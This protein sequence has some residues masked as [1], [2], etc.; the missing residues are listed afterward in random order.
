MYT[1]IWQELNG[2]DFI[3]KCDRLETKKE[4]FNLLKELK[5]NPDVCKNDVFIFLPEE[6]INRVAD[7]RA[8]LEMGY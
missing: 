7:I 8:A 3:D 5:N 1:V 4:V 2:N 6:E